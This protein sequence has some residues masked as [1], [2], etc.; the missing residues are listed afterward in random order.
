MTVSTTIA[1][2]TYDGDGSTVIFPTVFA[3]FAEADIEVIERNVASGLETVKTLTSDYTVTGGNGAPGNVTALVAPPATVSWTIRRVLSETQ[4]T[5]L[6]VA[7]SLPSTSVESIGDRNVMMIQ[8][9][10]EVL[11]RSLSFPKTDSSAISTELPSSV[12]RAGKFMGFDDS[13]NVVATAGTTSVELGFQDGSAASPS[14][15]FANESDKGFYNAEAGAI[16][17]ALAGV[18]QALFTGSGLKLKDGTAGLPPLAFIDDLDTGMS[19][20]MADTLGISAKGKLSLV[21]ASGGAAAV[22]YAQ[23]VNSITGT[24]I[25]LQAQG[26]DVNIGIKIQPKGTGQIEGPDGTSGRPGYSFDS[27]VDTGLSRPATDTLALSTGGAERA[28]LD[29][30]GRFGVN[31]TSPEGTV[32]VGTGPQWSAQNFGASLVIDGVRNN[33][34]AFLNSAIGGNPWAI[35]NSTIDALEFAKM[36]SLGDTTTNRKQVLVLF[37][38]GDV[39]IG[40]GGGIATNATDGFLILPVMSG[41][42]TGTP[43]NGGSQDAVMAY[44]KT[45]N[46]LKIFVN[47]GWRTVSTAVQ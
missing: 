17:V 27:D 3:F 47:G 35:A 45:N 6:P 11:S 32:H 24:A 19:R 23:V 13:G 16:G 33:A 36:P 38:D 4:E 43:T 40:E 46:E 14:I 18:Q 2:K 10:S 29:S 37:E 12:E 30:N 42:A 26:S 44:D 7:G 8:Q 22:N 41:D 15:T 31:E 39:R 34:I 20:P 21:V 1:S 25:A 9:H 28:R 5:D